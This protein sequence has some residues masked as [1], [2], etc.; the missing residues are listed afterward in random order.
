MPPENKQP[1][2]PVPDDWEDDSDD[3]GSVDN[4][5][6]RNRRI[7]KEANAK[8]PSPMPTVVVSSSSSAHQPPP[9][10]AFQPALRILKR[11][12]PS[13]T[14]LTPN[15]SGDTPSTTLKEREARYQAARDRIFGIDSGT[16]SG[17]A[18][19][20]NII[21]TGS[22]NTSPIASPPLS[23]TGAS[24]PLSTPTARILRE[25]RGPSESSITEGHSHKGFVHRRKESKLASSSIPE[26]TS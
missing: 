26:T 16:E 19:S 25:P 9:P 8:V 20:T 22:P 13:S 23:D 7:W 24:S 10:A 5:E 11:P 1:P 12:S 4:E 18:G 6:E 21:A 14:P 17:V 2:P 15:A 3:D